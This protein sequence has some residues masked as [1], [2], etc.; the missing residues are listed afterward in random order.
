MDY[1]DIFDKCNTDGGYFGE[2]RASGDRY[3]SLPVMESL[4][5]ADMIFQ[6]KEGIMWSINNYLGLAENE[7]IK[8]VA[9]E[10]AKEWG[11]SGPMGARI[12]SGNTQEHVTLEEEL[13]KFTQKEST[14]LFNY[15]YL[16]VIGTINSI[17]G[18]NDIIVSDQLCH[19]SIID[20]AKIACQDSKNI[21]VFKHNDMNNLDD[22]LKKV[23]ETRKGGVIVLTEGVF[24][25]TGDIAKLDQ[26]CE[27]K[28]KYEARLFID[29]AHG[30]GVM[31]P[32]GR[33]TAE[34]FN[35][36]DKVDIHLGTFAKAFASIGGFASAN[37]NVVEWIRYN[38]RTQVFAK[39][40]PMIYVKSLRKTL[41]LVIS[42]NARRKKLFEMSALLSNGL[43]ELGFYVP[44]VKSPIVSVFVPGGDTDMGYKWMA[45]FREN[46]IFVTGIIYPVIP[47]G[48]VLFRM[49]PTA[50][51]NIVHIEK[52]LDVFKKLKNKFDLK[53]NVNLEFIDNFYK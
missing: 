45:F 15:G 49:I 18:E 32:N 2:L 21:K 37:K 13:A 14:I 41:E 28:D 6:G 31:G 51:H 5:G 34:H 23:N 7:E 10:T 12:M 38:A 50:S 25:M 33:G 19:A 24:G 29:D 43:R 30:V 44:Q 48:L 1:S 46:G 9:V 36:Q 4:P 40:L 53:L 35:V 17:V 52:T 3:F 39:S 8:N 47:K 42:G 20:G 22:I 11:A 16:G 27:I 26:I